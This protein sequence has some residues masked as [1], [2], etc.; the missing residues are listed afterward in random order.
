MLEDAVARKL[1]LDRIEQQY[2]RM[3]LES[4]GGNK[5][6][7]ASILKI[8]RKTLYRKLGETTDEE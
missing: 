2:A 5:T 8:D 1:S 7:A 3:I 6:E 4:V